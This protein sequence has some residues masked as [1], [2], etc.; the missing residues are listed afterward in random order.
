[1]SDL[2]NTITETRT[3]V[4]EVK[5]FIDGMRTSRDT[6]MADLNALKNQLKEQ[7]QRLIQVTQEKTKL[8][9]KNLVNQK[10]VEEGRVFEVEPYEERNKFSF[11]T[12]LVSHYV[13]SL[14]PEVVEITDF[15]LKKEEKE[16]V[17]AELRKNL[18]QLKETENEKREAVETNKQMLMDHRDKLKQMIEACK[19]L[20]ENFDQKRRDVR[21]EKQKKIRELTDPN[22]A[23]GGGFDDEPTPAADVAEPV[24]APAA[25]EDVFPAAAVV[26]AAA[27][28]A[29]TSESAAPGYLQYQALYDYEARNEDELS[30]SVNDIIM[31]HPE[32]EHEP[33][34]LGGELNGKIGWFPEA[35]AQRL[36]EAGTLQPIQEVSETGSDN[37]SLQDP[38]PVVVQDTAVAVEPV[39]G[40]GV[41]NAAGGAESVAQPQPADQNGVVEGSLYVSVYPYSSEEPGDLIFDLGETIN[42]T[43]KNGDWWTGN[44]GDRS[45]V[46]P[47]NYVEPASSGDKS[48]TSVAA[49]DPV[50][51]FDQQ[52]PELGRSVSQDNG[53][54]KPKRSKSIK[55]DKA[56]KMEIAKVIAPY[57]AT[58]KEQLTLAQGQMVL[59]RKKTETG[60]WQGELQAGGKGK[61]RAVGWFPAS[62]VQLMAAA[63]KK[64]SSASSV[65]SSTPAAATQQGEKYV[66]LYDYN[67][68]YEDELSFKEGDVLNVV[69]KEEADWWRG[70]LNDKEGVF[71]AN[72][73]E[74]A[75]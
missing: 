59:I 29:A 49:A 46:F 32:Q 38:G 40:A 35:Y 28:T 48:G 33:G 62:Y 65:A 37:G 66:A 24:P 13:S 44:I 54:Q 27:T 26:P 11:V 25:A 6:K 64:T 51:T 9:S 73:V 34:W 14:V 12:S 4:T 20:H 68:Q 72:Y 57:A 18:E 19:A 55:K 47:Y 21:A 30:F 71:P 23:W 16:N 58:S 45:G 31:V 67:G 60:W 8:E 5:A 10:K 7:N 52:Q 1:M 22:H 53:G 15:D 2:T 36:A 56:G 75:K 42:V 17:V 41:E 63:E 61:K 70:V 50:V 74:P 43:A 69:N 3:G 39:V